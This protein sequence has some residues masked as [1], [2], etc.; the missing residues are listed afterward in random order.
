MNKNDIFLLKEGALYLLSQPISQSEFDKFFH[1]FNFLKKWNAVFNLTSIKQ[2]TLIV[3]QH[4][5]DCLSVIR[6]LD[7]QNSDSVFDIGSGAGFPGLVIA[8]LRPHWKIYLIEKC[9]KKVTFLQHVRMELGLK[10]VQIF[11]GN[12]KD[13][14]IK[15]SLIYENNHKLCPPIIICRALTSLKKFLDLTAFFLN[16]GCTW[17]AMKGK[18]PEKEINELDAT[19]FFIKNMKIY[20]PFL[21]A[22]R[23]VVLF[24]KMS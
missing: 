11:H 14:S 2:D 5:L 20:V 10:N 23:H 21:D 4:F 15:F 1:F 6:I 19:V 9:N 24:K 18:D 3:R 17:V 22:S 13:L 12:V 8:I 16:T 7:N